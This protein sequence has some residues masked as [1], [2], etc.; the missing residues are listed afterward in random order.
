EVGARQRFL[1]LVDIRRMQQLVQIALVVEHQ[2]QVNLRLGF[3]M[4]IDR[5]FADTHGI[6]NHL[7]G[8]AVFTLIEEQLE[9]G[10][11]NFLLAA[12]KLTDL[13][14]FFLHKK[15]CRGQ[16]RSRVLCLTCAKLHGSSD[17]GA[18]YW[19]KWRNWCHA[20]PMQG[21]SERR[22]NCG[23]SSRP[24][25]PNLFKKCSELTGRPAFMTNT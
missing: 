21:A 12:S 7:D 14:G 13:S 9:R 24:A 8:D 15:V 18:V 10:I 20:P 4:L 6:S 1:V 19:P 25:I 16:N 3:E 22:D 5:A 17:H 2:A 11:E 23:L